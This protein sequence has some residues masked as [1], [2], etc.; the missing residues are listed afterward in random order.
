MAYINQEDKK[1]LAPEIKKVCKEY[2]VKATLAID[3]YSTLVLNIKS[4]SIDFFKS[5]GHEFK[6]SRVRDG[7]IQVN[8]YCI[9][10]WYKV[11]AKE[12]FIKVHKAMN[13]GNHDNSDI[14]TDY[15][16][17]GWYTNINIGQL[18]KPYTLTKD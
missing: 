1:R 5:Y 14:M 10:D 18:D 17:V 15:F 12:F 2:G 9:E 7:Y 4:G 3:H 16:D 8:T 11:I 6:E 13:C